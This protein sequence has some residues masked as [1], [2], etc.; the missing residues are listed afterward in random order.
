VCFATR[1]ANLSFFQLRHIV[2][3]V[4][5]YFPPICLCLSWNQK[6]QHLQTDTRNC[7]EGSDTL[8]SLV[9]WQFFAEVELLATSINIITCEGL[10]RSLVSESQHDTTVIYPIALVFPIMQSDSQQQRC[11][12]SDI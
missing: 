9:I 8:L 5:S 4:P 6:S 12:N 2:Y 1:S 3:D 10:L 11:I 7:S